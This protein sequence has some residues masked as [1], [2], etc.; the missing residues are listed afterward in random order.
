MEKQNRS[1]PPRGSDPAIRVDGL[2]K[3]YG[4]TMAVDDLSFSVA[5]GRV[6]GFLGPNG[7]G[8]TTTL[9]ALLGLI[10]PTVGTATVAG[11]PYPAL[12]EPTRTVGALLDAKAAH[13]GRSGRDQLRVLAQAAGI[14]G[15]RVDVLLEQ[16]GLADVAGQRVSGY[17]LGMRQRLGLAA[18]LLG[19]PEVLILDEPANGLDPEG[20]RWFR[21]LVRSFAAEGRAVLVSSHV[22][23][24]VAQSADDVVVVRHG[25]SVLQAPLAELLARHGGGVRVTG[26]DA[27][28]LG[29]R[30]RPQGAEVSPDGTDAVVIRGCGQDEVL[31]RVA[32]DQLAVSAVS[33]LAASLEDIYLG[34]TDDRELT[35][36]LMGRTR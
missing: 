10:R 28:V 18:A 3:R 22:L 33:P 24:E 12:A 9:R 36:E 17:S 23:A 21:D 16:V 7:A 32:R 8:K 4:P 27:V 1:D 25:R 13:P 11:C 14:P 2:T 31:H 15:G 6:V 35:S 29:D 34:L 5:Y 19:D 20:I 26:P 30:L